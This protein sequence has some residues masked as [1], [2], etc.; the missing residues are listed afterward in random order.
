LQILIRQPLVKALTKTVL[1]RYGISDDSFTWRHDI[2]LDLKRLSIRKCENLVKLLEPHKNLFGTKTCIKEIEVF[3]ASKQGHFPAMMKVKLFEDA[4]IQYL[5]PTKRRWL[6]HKSDGYEN[7][8]IASSVTKIEFHPY[9][10]A[11]RDTSAQPEYVDVQFMYEQF[12]E[13]NALSEQFYADDIL[14]KKVP[15]IL[16]L[17]GYYLETDDLRNKY[18][19]HLKKYTEIVPLIGKQYILSGVAVDDVPDDLD[20]YGHT[21]R[22]REKIRDKVENKVVI[23]IFREKEDQEQIGWSSSRY[24]RQHHESGGYFWRN[25]EYGYDEEQEFD[26]DPTIEKPI[27]PF[28]IIFDLQRHM[29]LSTHI[30]T[31]EEYKYETDISEKLILPKKIKDLVNILIE[32]KS[33]TFVDIIRGKSGGE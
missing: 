25:I 10:K 5:L 29:R 9:E 8:W 17:R 3:L 30:D 23:D 14:F 18:L 2:D 16:A 4:L 27:H 11:T 20:D 32:H 26:R 22:V 1:K 12:A 6:Y 28:V 15:E 7:Q 33:G 21:S 24:S 13:E 31:L 19:E